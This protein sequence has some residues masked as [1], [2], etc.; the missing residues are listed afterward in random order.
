MQSRNHIKRYN[1]TF[2]S[3]KR[4]HYKVLFQNRIIVIIT[5]AVVLFSIQAQQIRHLGVNDGLNGRQSF[6][7]VQ[8]KEG[9]IWIS[10][11]FGIDRYDGKKI[12]NYRI[13]TLNET[14]NPVREV[15]I[16]SDRD[17][18]LWAY[19]DNGGI[20]FY[21]DLK[22][23]FIGY[24]HLNSYLKTVFF[25]TD[26]QLW[27]GVNNAFGTII[28]G[29]VKY[30]TSPQLNFQL[31]RKILHYDKNRLIV[32]STKSIHIYDKNE[33]TFNNFFSKKELKLISSLQIESAYFD[34]KKKDLW[35]GTTNSGLILFNQRNRQFIKLNNTNSAYN[36]I[37]SIYPVDENHIFFGTDGMG[38]S[39]LDR[40]TLQIVQTYKQKDSGEFPLSGNGVYDIFKDKDGRI[41][42]S[43]FSDGVNILD[44]R[45]GSFTTL[46]HEKNN[47]KSII[48][49]VVTS[50]I[51]DSNNNL[52]IC[53]NNGISLW[54]RTNNNWKHLLYTLNVLTVFEDSKRNI[55]VGT[56]ANGVYQLN[57]NGDIINHF[58]RRPGVDK[59]IGSNFIYSI[60][61]DSNNNLWFGGIKGAL[62]KFDP[63][64]N[65]YKIIQL[66]QINNIKQIN[67][68]ELL[69]AT[70][71]GLYLLNLNNDEL[72]P[73]QFNDNLYSRCI[74]DIL[75]HN[76]SIMWISSYG[77]GICKCNLKTGEIFQYSQKDGL[78]SGITFSI[79]EDNDKNLWI[80]SEN[81]VSK[82]N[83]KNDS[84]TNFTTGDG[85]SDLSFRPLSRT[86]TR[87]GEILFG[88]YNGLTLFRPEAIAPTN[89]DTKLYLLEFSLFNRVTRPGEYKSPLKSKI[90]ET[91]EII[92]RHHDHSFSLN[93]TTINF[94]PNAKRQYMWMLEGLDKTWIG[95]STETVVNYTNLEPKTY[96]FKLKAIGDNNIVLDQRELKVTIKPPFWNTTLAKIIA[97]ILFVLIGYWGYQYISERY[98]KKRTAEK[99]K[100]FINTTHDLRTPLTLITSP[101]YELKEKMTQDNWSKYLFDLVTNNL[102][103]MNKMVSQLL[104][105]QKSYETQ[106]QLIITK[107]SI[108]ALVSEK[109]MYWLPVAE[110]K[111][112]KLQFEAPETPLYEWFDKEKLEKIVDNLISNAI[113]YTRNNG[114][115]L[116]KLS[117][118]SN[119]WQLNVVDN[120]I[121]I[122]EHALRKL[123]QRFY[124]AE[125]AINSQETGS[126]LGL[127][128][129]KNYVSLHKG[130]IGVNSTENNGS[131]FFVR[132]RRGSKHYKNMI[133][134]E[135]G[136]LEKNHGGFLRS[137]NKYEHKTKFK[138]LIVEDN[139]D[140]R[141]YLK[142]SLSHY[143]VI[144]TA[145]N[146]LD[147]WNKIPNINPDVIISDY[148]MPEMNGFELCK[149]IK[150]NFE[151]SH[152]PVILLTVMTDEKHVE[153][154]LRI[155]ADDYI[156]KPFDVKYLKNKIDNIINN[157]KILRSK[158]LDINK[159]RESDDE[160]EN[161]HNLEFINKATAIIEEHMIDNDFSITDFSREMG[162]SRSLLYTK[163]NAVTG[164]SPN[165]F[166]KIIRMKRAVKLFKENRY[167]IN[168]VASMTGFEEASY[169]TTCFKKIY[170]KS[171][172]QF[173]REDIMPEEFE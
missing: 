165:D 162:M 130:K 27:F 123:F 54:N 13:P 129:I 115:V 99:I 42:M 95:P 59:S 132:F 17:S 152:I 63:K 143:Y 107:N 73:W 131:D 69:I 57:L 163:F 45:R 140:L 48:T 65:T 7:F 125:N 20:Y 171:P 138:V 147:A 160:M 62:T 25:D 158:F 102:E 116:T 127:L 26:N 33:N 137:E 8:D 60:F 1:L 94:A 133:L 167:S 23:D 22:D 154:G 124:R 16:L 120:G 72:K 104:D 88:S 109:I 110:R 155:G 128:L 43:T 31:V 78:A 50:I 32:V 40:E 5:F 146:G 153:E 21:D 97:V 56:Y 87:S 81:G 76:D 46:R 89:H 83:I 111:N 86:K 136:I 114:I 134:D 79:L 105:F 52:W 58:Q 148:N 164:Y 118:S 150:E 126:G 173:I 135:T 75:P 74:F 29:K 9:F 2:Y 18:L 101:I 159:P 51:E 113:K 39:L 55:W 28:D 67:K 6:N 106:E 166:I 112:I 71:S 41:W 77:G 82:I 4:N 68:E 91:S 19:T 80:S 156:Q 14:K 144:H 119:Y 34:R 108:N 47:S 85:L 90:N 38:A 141:E 100:F 117:Y 96:I 49:N 15:H 142:L 70:V 172:K 122:P 11:R 103:K 161:N 145:E 84:I 10:N 151:T 3:N 37:L 139:P 93:F 168:E 35:I 149:K 170:G 157:R 92:L 64:N 30:I 66:Y 44:S 53:T 98:E 121:G 24:K 61:E 36:P 169:F 12:K